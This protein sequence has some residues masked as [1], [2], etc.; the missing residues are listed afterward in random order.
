ME[1]I[2]GVFLMLLAAVLPLS[3][4]NLGKY[5]ERK[6]ERIGAGNVWVMHGPAVE[7]DKANGGFMN[8]PAIIEGKTGLIVIDPGANYKVGK[9]VLEEIEKVSK[10]PI[11]AIINTHKHGDHWFANIALA[12]KYPKV[13]IYAHPR[14]IKEVKEGEAENWYGILDRLTKNME[15]TKPFKYPFIEI[16][17]GDKLT[18]DGE[19][20]LIRH[21]ARTHTDTD[22]MIA[23]PGSGTF[24]I[25]DN[26]M[27]NRLGTFDGSSSILGNIALLERVKKET[28]YQHYIPGHGPSGSKSEVI[29]PYLTYL[30]TLAKWAKKAYENDEEYYTVKKDALKELA[31]F[32]NW[33]AFDRQMGKHLAKVYREIEEKDME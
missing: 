2:R 26:V 12:Q 16:R 27:R 28:D 33:D 3:A 6:F 4:W 17:D 14:M 8:N 24:F 30:S 5:G 7:P 18:I 20:F 19:T 23:H 10:K 22:L 11:V 15:G 25:A 9:K 31:A 29:D 21:P 13:Q 32:K 1:W